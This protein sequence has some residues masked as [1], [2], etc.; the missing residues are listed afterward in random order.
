MQKD[1]R[2]I[3]KGNGKPEHEGRYKVKYSSVTGKYKYWD[4]LILNED[5]MFDS[6]D[7]IVNNTSYGPEYLKNIYAVEF[8][9]ILDKLIKTLKRK[10]GGK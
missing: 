1:F 8:Y 5:S 3:L 9:K 7:I 2:R 10:H 6:F 4:K